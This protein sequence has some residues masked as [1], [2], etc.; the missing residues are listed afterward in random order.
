MMEACMPA[1][2]A[3]VQSIEQWITDLREANQSPQTVLNHQY[4]MRSFVHWL[5]SLPEPIDVSRL[6]TTLLSTYVKYLLERRPRLRDSTIFAYIGVLI[7]WLGFLIND[8]KISG[9]ANHRGQLVTPDRVRT[10]LDRL[11]GKRTPL[12]A[13]RIPDLRALPAYYHYELAAFVQQ[14]G[15]PPK[16]HPPAILRTYLN[17]LRN[18]AL[19]GVLFS[20]GGRV[21]EVLQLSVRDVWNGTA[22]NYTV[23][24]KGKGKRERD[25]RLDDLAQDWIRAYLKARQAHFPLKGA[26]LFIS[27]GPTA[28]GLQI[29]D[30]T[31]WRV[32]KDAAHAL[33]DQWMVQGVAHEEIAAL[34]AVSPHSLRHF[35]AQA[36]LDEGANY[37]DI[38]FVLGH[39]S[40]KVTQQVYARLSTERTQEI[41]DTYAPRA[42][43]SLKTPSKQ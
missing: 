16:A 29:S 12:V 15:D 20:T 41:A 4:A 13:P 18:R 27:H 10:L 24:I 3:L 43:L 6:T 26:P 35:F 37:D 5:E 38:A 7:R 39:S 1:S 28:K 36:M 9:V 30:V 32:V 33:A 14:H 31:A 8:G 23:S 34:R 42:I 25:L 19:I 21:N 2:D 11:V 40:T 17:L 22:V